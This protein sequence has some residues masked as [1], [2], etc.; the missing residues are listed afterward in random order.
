MPGFDTFQSRLIVDATLETLSPLHVGAGRSTDAIASDLPVLKDNYG[1]P[2]IPGS[3]LKGAIR[4]H[5]ESVLRALQLGNAQYVGEYRLVCDPLS[6]V[7]GEVC[8]T[9]KEVAQIK[10]TAPDLVSRDQTL[11][12][13]SCLTCRVFGAPWLAAKLKIRDLSMIVDDVWRPHTTI[14]DGVSI[15]RDKGTVVQKFDLEVVPAHTHFE[16]KMQV[17]NATDA[18]MGLVL[19]I[20]QALTGQQIQIGGAHR[21]GA[22]W[23]RL[24]K[25]ETKVTIYDNPTDLLFGVDPDVSVNTEEKMAAFRALVGVG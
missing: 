14:R 21:A 17:D 15:D 24:L 9:K 22:G 13:H 1:Y 4:S 8:L 7:P 10:D 3:S 25:N 18:E 12:D 23:C 6:S 11:L 16:L 19:L 2:V 20:V 5:I